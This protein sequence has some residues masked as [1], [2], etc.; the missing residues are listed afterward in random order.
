MKSRSEGRR[1]R[2]KRE[3]RARIQ[4]SAAALFLQLGFDATTVE[5][6]AEAADVAQA[7]FFNHFPSKKAVLAEMTREVHRVIRVLVEEQRKEALTTQEK[8]SRMAEDAARLVEGAHHLARDI[9]LS[10]MRDTGSHDTAAP[11]LADVREVFAEFIRDG[12]IAGDVRRDEDARFLSEMLIGAFHATVTNWLNEPSYP[13]AERL[14]RAAHFIGGA[15]APRIG[16]SPGSS[17]GPNS[18]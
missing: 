17:R 11:I 9:L 13:L 16:S 7:T 10:L 1:E 15:L 14:Q 4:H 5:Q 12:Q 2:K 6:I 18:G 8:L 3:L